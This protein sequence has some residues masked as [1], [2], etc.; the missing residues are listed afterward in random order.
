MSFSYRCVCSFVSKFKLF[1]CK[2]GEKYRKFLEKCQITYHR[3]I[4]VAIITF[5]VFE[6]LMVNKF[7]MILKFSFTRSTWINLFFRN[8]FLKI[9][10]AS[11]FM[12]IFFVWLRLDYRMGFFDVYLKR[13]NNTGCSRWIWDILKRWL[14][15]RCQAFFTCTGRGGGK[16]TLRK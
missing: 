12:L 13:E 4:F 5:K 16:Y 6:L 9:T 7:L 15:F 11:I 2:K 3:K 1:F 14:H 8:R 10:I